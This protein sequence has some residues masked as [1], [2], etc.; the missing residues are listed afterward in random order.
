MYSARPGTR[1]AAMEADP[2]LAVS[3]DQKN[4]RRVELERLQERI[5]TETNAR[6]LGH[7]VEVLVEGEHRGKWRGRTAGNK[8]V[9]FE[10][11]ADWTG[12]LARA[13]VTQTG[14]WSLQGRLIGEALPSASLEGPAV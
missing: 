10:D 9:F 6:L 2:T 7:T 12:R 11:A 8:L 3:E 14:P 5:A 4:I 13:N 1:A